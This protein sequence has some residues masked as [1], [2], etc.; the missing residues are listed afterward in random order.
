MLNNENEMDVG[1]A[2]VAQTEGRWLKTAEAPPFCVG[3]ESR[4]GTSMLKKMQLPLH[5]RFRF[6]PRSIPSHWKT[7]NGKGSGNM[8]EQ[9]HQIH[10]LLGGEIIQ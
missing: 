4:I 9:I 8:I 10:S 6:H 5:P 2:A 1:M 3:K 7:K